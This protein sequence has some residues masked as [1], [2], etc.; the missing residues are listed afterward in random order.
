MAQIKGDLTNVNDQLLLTCDEHF[1]SAEANGAVSLTLV[2]GASGTVVIESSSGTDST[3]ADVW[4]QLE[5]YCD[6]AGVSALQSSLVGAAGAQHGRT[7]IVG[8][9]K[10][11]ARKSVT[12]ASCYC[13]L[14]FKAA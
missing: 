7:E 2:P 6:Q 11:R 12:A 1:G 4:V 3:G 13:I 10:I 8:A 5:I 14:S 9:K